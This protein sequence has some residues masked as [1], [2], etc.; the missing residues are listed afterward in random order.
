MSLVLI[1]HGGLLS[2]NSVTPNCLKGK[3]M[4]LREGRGDPGGHGA[5]FLPGEAVQ[6][7]G[8]TNPTSRIPWLPFLP[9]NL[10]YRSGYGELVQTW[11]PPSIPPSI[12]QLRHCAFKRPISWLGILVTMEIEPEPSSRELLLAA[13]SPG[14]TNPSRP[15]PCHC[16]L[17]F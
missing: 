12:P 2:S 7:V 9:Q 3:F 17:L 6:L 14:F 11:A 5:T 10:H 4:K 8:N 15:F 16:Q 13:P 1:H